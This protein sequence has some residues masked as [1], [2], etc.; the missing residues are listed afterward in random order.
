[1]YV[2][3]RAVIANRAGQDEIDIV[4]DA[5]VHDA[6]AQ[7]A[8]GDG[9]GNAAG[10]ANGVDRAHVVFV[11]FVRQRTF[12]Q[13]D[14]KRSAIERLFYVVGR[15]PVSRKQQIDI[16]PFDHFFKMLPGARVDYRRT[17]YYQHFSARFSCRP[18]LLGNLPNYRALGFFARNIAGHEFEDA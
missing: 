7:N 3:Q 18:D 10:R 2:W 1:Y 16:A 14:P 4:F 8:M 5:G 15:E 12:N 11:T 6:L 9:L 13:I 17:S